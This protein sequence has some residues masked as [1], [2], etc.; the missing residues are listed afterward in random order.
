MK[1]TAATS[2]L[3]RVLP[4][5]LH[6]HQSHHVFNGTFFLLIIID[7]SIL[8]YLKIQTK[9]HVHTGASYLLP[10]VASHTMPQANSQTFSKNSTA[11]PPHHP[12]PPMPNAGQPSPPSPPPFPPFYTLA[13]RTATTIPP[14]K[15]SKHLKNVCFGTSSLCLLK[16]PKPHSPCDRPPP[17]PTSPAG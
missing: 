12:S 15:T 10:N 3:H 5:P 11:P 4:P 14:Q 9:K 17:C 1:F 8:P 6:H 16:T 13:T 7:P 2:H